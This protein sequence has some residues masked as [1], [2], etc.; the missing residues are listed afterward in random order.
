MAVSPHI[1]SFWIR[2]IHTVSM[3]FLL[4]GTLLMWVDTLRPRAEGEHA[5]HGPLA[6]RFE[7]FFWLALGVQVITGIGN[8][9]AFGAA[10]PQPSSAWGVNLLLKLGLVLGLFLLSLLR[11]VIIARLSRLGSAVTP[12]GR[13]LGST[14]YGATAV[15][16]AGIVWIAVS[17]AH[18]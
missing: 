2:W 18:G 9:G 6:E 13:R 8:L 12:Y 5:W 15:V 17:L 11:T 4:G 1:L 3:G 16:L 10:L 14:L 7:L